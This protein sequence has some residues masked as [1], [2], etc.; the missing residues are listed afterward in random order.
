MPQTSALAELTGKRLW[1]NDSEPLPHLLPPIFYQ[2]LIA[3]LALSLLGALPS[4]AAEA[5]HAELDAKHRAFFKNNCLTCHNAE[6]QK[7]KVRLD[8]IAFTI[9][10]VERADLWQKVLNSIN[11]GDMPPEDEKQPAPDAKTD[12]LDDLSRTLV[13]ARGRLSDSGG[14]I[15]MRRLNRREYKNTLRDL[16]G[17]DINVRELPADGG[18]GNFDTVGSS[19]FMS[20]DQF[21]QYLALGRQA[22]DEHFARFI[23][24]TSAKP[25]SLHVEVEE[26]NAKI[27]KSLADRT[28]AHDRYMKWTAAVEAA[29]QKPENTAI[30]TQI[31]AEKK[32]NA[33]HLYSQW[34]RIQGAPAP[35]DF[36]FV[37]EINADEQ[38]RRNWVH[39][40]PYQKAYL[41][42]P[43]TK[44][45]TFLTIED[46]FVNP[47]QPFRIPGDWPAGD[48]VVRVRIA[49]T[50]NTPAARHF[51][52]FGSQHDTGVRAVASSH[53]IT[54]TME[55]PQVLE[56]P[57]KFSP[58]KG[59]G[60]FFQ[61]KGSY[62]SEDLAHRI[63]AE[64]K[65]R[66]GIGPEFALWID[67]IEVVSAADARL[68][69]KPQTFKARTEAEVM[70]NRQMDGLFKK[71]LEQHQNHARWA[72]AVD[73]AAARPENV[74]IA[75]ELREKAKQPRPASGVPFASPL[76]FY[77]DWEQIKGAPSPVEFGFKDAQQAFVEENL[78]NQFFPYY[79]DY[80]KLPARDKGAWLMFYLAY[81]ETYVEAGKKWPAGRYTLRMRVAANPAAPPERCFIEIGQRGEDVSQFTVLGAHQVTGTLAQPQIIETTVDV[82]PD[83][84]REFAVRERRPN[85]RQAEVRSYH[86]TFEKT[87]HG[88]VPAIWMDWLEIEGPAVA[89]ALTKTIKERREVELHANRMV[90]GT[91]NGYFKGGYEA[92]KKF[93]ET[94]KPQKGIP[95]ATEAKFR[96]MV[97]EQNGPTFERYLNDPLTKTGAYL[98]IY[99]VHTE[100]VITLPP[101]QPSGWLKTKHE[102][103][104]AAPGEYMLR[105]RIGAVQGTSKERHF[106]ALGSRKNG[107]EDFTLLET[108]QISGSTD[109]PQIIEVPVSI[110][111]DGP[112]TFVLR[113]KRDVKLDNDIYTAARK[114]TKVGPP[115][116]L[117]IDWVEWEGPLNKTETKS[118]IEPVLFANTSG[119]SD[120]DHAR[121]VLQAFAQR[122]FRAKQPSAAYLDKLTALYDTRRKAGDAHEAA[123]KE[124]LS[125]V[126]AS[127]G[128]L[129]LQETGGHS[130]TGN[131]PISPSHRP[132]VSLSHRPIVSLSPAELASRLSYFL[133]SAPPDEQLLKANLTQPEVLA[134]EV[135]RMI[136]SDKAD[137]FVSGFV[138]QW[139]GMDRLEFFQFDTKQFRDFDE[140]AKAAARREVYE[141]FAYLLRQRGS[142][143]KLLK[144]DEVHINGL[145][146]TYYG[147][148]GVSG[149]D[150]QKVTLPKDSPR[151][152]LL[153]MAAIL[154]MG[155]NGERTSPVERGAWVLR[156]LLHNPPPPAPP[157]VPQLDR[158]STKPI[159]PHDRLIAHQEQPQC[160]QCHRKIDPIG[161]GLENFNA[162]GKWRDL[163]HDP[164]TKK[165][166]PIDPA[167]Q[168]YNGP[169]FKSY[170]DLRDLIAARSE[171]FAQGFTEAL[172]EYALGRPYG[173]TDEELAATIVKQ[174][175]SKDFTLREFIVAL[176]QSPQFQRK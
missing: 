148:E 56:I 26:K 32:D 61:E 106:V 111:A 160:L 87:G 132:L 39:C 99:N 137:E 169:A 175:K 105:F 108:F 129:Y 159:S 69:A 96:V 85:T 173:F 51:V 6:K 171:N 147:I 151:G 48:Y 88:P 44:T 77:L 130:N 128:F 156:K 83:G 80:Q 138:H 91:Y 104:K 107:D 165:D 140:S 164:K 74:K 101:D 59:H 155:S 50:S 84:K 62:E 86:D 134:R 81:R 72:A 24:P 161:F 10:S 3:T 60:F 144:S 31:R 5:P 97:F 125:V 109:A 28:D 46:V 14:N 75:A 20:S 142:L 1:V 119:L 102:M 11:S 38:G 82:K 166:W 150:F 34:Q 170:F 110:S 172:I 90:G 163:D 54:G 149:D 93:L 30:V 145:L 25:R 124:P 63:F 17:V 162:A 29:A 139:L 141:T 27:A 16:L 121:A 115:P 157:N 22:L 18:A 143:S 43:A 100:E 94:G 116:A 21:E 113:E 127:P 122:A 55:K 15:A 152:G 9:D 154:A 76:F 176:V 68:V 71:T 57:L 66:N 153:G 65:Q 95:D 4:H 79:E 47:Y 12:F 53:H 168:L 8:D 52:E 158:L 41:N 13:T 133:W 112:R 126:L 120:H 7:G 67:W 123:L 118:A 78:Y 89:P 73:A 19:L 42:H 136:A 36:D 146:A 33:T 103:E 35:K 98:T 64:G 45:G 23:A 114:Q 70:G 2:L 37:D 58:V 135:D 131:S 117:W 174:T 92:A 40:V 167:G 49:A